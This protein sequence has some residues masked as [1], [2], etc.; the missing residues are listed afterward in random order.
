MW[1]ILIRCMRISQN[2][3]LFISFIYLF[4]YFFAIARSKP[5]S[6]PFLFSFFSVILLLIPFAFHIL[7]GCPKQLGV[8]KGQSLEMVP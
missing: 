2:L 1:N 4:I 5:F 3:D 6:C 7:S 8:N